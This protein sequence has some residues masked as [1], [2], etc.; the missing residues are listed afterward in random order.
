[1]KQTFYL[2]LKECEFRFNHRHENL[3]N[4]LLSLFRKHPLN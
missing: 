2:H 1:H 4:L 3:Y